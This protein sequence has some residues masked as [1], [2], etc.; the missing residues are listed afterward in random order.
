MESTATQTIATIAFGVT[1]TLLSV[2]TV[3]QGR[4]AWRRLYGQASERVAESDVES[5]DY[6]LLDRSPKGALIHARISRT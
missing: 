5:R 1:A 6:L 3:W 2:F 4:R